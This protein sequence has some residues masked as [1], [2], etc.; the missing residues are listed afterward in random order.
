MGPMQITSL[1]FTR[2]GSAAVQQEG[3]RSRCS[4]R[5]RAPTADFFGD[6]T[7]A[8][9]LSQF[10]PAVAIVGHPELVNVGPGETDRFIQCALPRGRR[11]TPKYA[12]DHAQQDRLFRTRIRNYRFALLITVL[13]FAVT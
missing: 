13:T 5:E 7:D 10:H 1:N 6:G 8:N 11:G 4:A 12:I 9:R 3:D 2:S